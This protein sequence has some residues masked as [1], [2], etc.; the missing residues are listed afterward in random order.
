MNKPRI[1]I[2]ITIQF[3]VR[4]L[5]RTGLLARLAE[6]TQ[7]VVLLGWHDSTL[8]EEL[9]QLGSEVL[10]LPETHYGPAYTSVR[11]KI[12]IWHFDRLDSPTT[13]I[14]RRRED[15][16][17]SRRLRLVK[18]LRGLRNRAYLSLP[19]YAGWLLEQERSLL[20]S[21]T[22]LGEFRQLIRSLR[23]DALLSLTPFHKPEEL[24]VRVAAAERLKTCAAILS[25][26]NVTVRGWIGA[27]FDCYLLWNRHNVEQLLRGYPQAKSR[28]VAIVGAPQFDFYWRPEY[29]WDEPVWRERMALP[30]RRPVILYGG[31]PPFLVPNEPH[32]VMQLDDAIERGELPDRPV[33]LLRRHPADTKAR[34]ESL[35][36]DA[37]HVVF[38]EPWP[39]GVVPKYS[40]IR[41][42]DIAK[43]TSTL[44]HSAVHVN[45][46]S[47]MTVD[48]AIFDRPQIGPAYDDRPGRRYDRMMREHY[49]YEHL[50][51]ITRSG[52]LDIVYDR[53]SLVRA[54][55]TGLKHPELRTA[56]R[57]RLVQE[58]IT[59]TDGQSTQRVLTELLRFVHPIPVSPA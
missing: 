2:P 1:L 48:G 21:E 3:S 27:L 46:A 39:S 40:N 28:H 6:H 44:K 10:E 29:G 31:G 20:E 11:R 35:L 19:G 9:E 45:V 50:L 51:P 37:K 42:S 30:P 52:G 47:T 59:F 32:L 41:D 22:N 54:V 26:D 57:K 36:R 33:I 18:Q 25:F 53:Q 56:G 38:D 13:A 55:T 24:L 16:D 12:D 34:W 49:L 8:R 17:A 4:Y 14:A 5:L 7:P 15:V 23:A 58:I 43:L